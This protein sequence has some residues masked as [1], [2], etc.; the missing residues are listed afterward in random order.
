MVA[1]GITTLLVLEGSG[2]I[3]IRSRLLTGNI[4]IGVVDL[5]TAREVDTTC[6]TVSFVLASDHTWGKG[7]FVGVFFVFFGVK[8]LR[9]ELVDSVYVTV[10]SSCFGCAVNLVPVV[11]VAAHSADVLVENF[12]IFVHGLDVVRCEVSD[13]FVVAWSIGF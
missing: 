8:R 2:R 1:F 12:Y 7:A 13:A 10:T 5:A 9:D 6:V 3:M 11:H 4:V